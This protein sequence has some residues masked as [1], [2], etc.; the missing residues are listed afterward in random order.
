MNN[1]FRSPRPLWPYE[2]SRN[3]ELFWLDKNEITIESA[4]SLNEA[5]LKQLKP[6]DLSIYPEL[7]TLYKLFEKIFRINQANTLLVNGADGGIREVYLSLNNDYQ[8]VILDPTFAMIGV[9]P[10]NLNNNYSQTK[11]EISNGEI[12]INLNKLFESLENTNKPPLLIIASPDS[13]TGSLLNEEKIQ[14]LI[15]KIEA[16][17]GIF[18]FDG[19]YSLYESYDYM[20]KVI[21]QLNCSKNCLFTTSFSK[22]PGLAGARLGFLTGSKKIIEKIRLIRPMYEV[23]ALQSKILSYILNDW[24]RVLD[25]IRD[26][27]TNKKELE[28]ILEK[29]DCLIVPTKGNFTLFQSTEAVNIALESLCYYRKFNNGCLKGLSRIST[30][31]SLFLKKFENKIKS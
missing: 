30:P 14:K 22:S 8:A 29:N 26:I 23:G 10:N 4:L 28:L 19:T 6:K 16:L 1:N 12:S 13:P 20:L 17:K 15:K 9:Y 2:E 27:K 31:P 11:Y 24:E 5:I 25:V 3:Q 18:L 7:G 21:Q